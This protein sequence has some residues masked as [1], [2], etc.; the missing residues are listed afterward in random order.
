LWE[1]RREKRKEGE[2]G[3]GWWAHDVNGWGKR[4]SLE[5]KRGSKG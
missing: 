1:K 4:K 5:G 3:R 2:K